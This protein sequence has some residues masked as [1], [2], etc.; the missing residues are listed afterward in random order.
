MCSH[1][2][3]SDKIDCMCWAPSDEL[4]DLELLQ[5]VLTSVANDANK[6]V[7]VGKLQSVA[8]GLGAEA[9]HE[10]FER[11]HLYMAR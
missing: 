5:S 6:A 1:V 2:T 7:I 10:L 4:E 11:L 3:G 9:K 8:H